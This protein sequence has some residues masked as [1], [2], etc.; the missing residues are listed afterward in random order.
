[1]LRQ[2]TRRSQQHG[3]MAIMATGMH[4]PSMLTGVFEGVHF[5]HGQGIHIGAQA[6]GT[7]TLA[8]AARYDPHHP[9]Y[10]QTTLHL[11]RSEERRVGQAWVSKCR[12]PGGPDT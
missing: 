9:G 1:M 7:P 5:L 6:Y 2:V 8:A 12:S 3:G 11:D 10:A 4:F